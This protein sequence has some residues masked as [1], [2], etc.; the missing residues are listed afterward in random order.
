M[1]RAF[2]QSELGG[3]TQVTQ[4]RLAVADRDASHCDG[5]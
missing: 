2:P 3:S 1:L 5:L 4:R